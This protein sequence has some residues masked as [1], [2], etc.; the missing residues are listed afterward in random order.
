MPGRGASPPA[1]TLWLLILSHADRLPGHGW[2]GAPLPE[3][4]PA[5]MGL[6]DRWVPGG[7][8]CH[9]WEARP[10]PRSA[11]ELFSS[12]TPCLDPLRRV[13]P[14]SEREPLSPPVPAHP[15]R[16][17]AGCQACVSEVLELVVLLSWVNGPLVPLLTLLIC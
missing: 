11:V 17:R 4:T 3:L 8:C 16:H 7:R 5:P 1:P 10:K 9:P 15:F 2:P 6:R 13:W 14:R 12:D